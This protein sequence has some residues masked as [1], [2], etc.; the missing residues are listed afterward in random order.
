M[1][2]KAASVLNKIKIPYVVILLSGIANF[3]LEEKGDLR[4]SPHINETA[5]FIQDINC[6]DVYISRFTPQPGTEIYNL[7]KANKL[8]FPSLSE[9]ELEHRM[10]IKAISY[11]E[12]NPLKPSREVR[13]TYGI[14]FNR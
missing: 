1:L 9:R 7:I 5:K 8:N 2:Y 10:M 13:G 11:N 12:K 3:T 6:S 4:Y 14:Q